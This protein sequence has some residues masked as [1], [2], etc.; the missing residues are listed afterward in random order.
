MIQILI[1]V[2][3]TL[4]LLF[5]LFETEPRAHVHW[6]LF[7]LLSL[8]LSL[9]VLFI[10]LLILFALLLTCVGRKLD[11]VGILSRQISV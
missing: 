2:H 6:L 3:R 11:K 4:Q 1:L 9:L 5:P 8:M 7:R 10:L